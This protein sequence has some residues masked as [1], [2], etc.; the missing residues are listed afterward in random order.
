MVK[1]THSGSEDHTHSAFAGAHKRLEQMPLS[2]DLDERARELFRALKPFLK[3]KPQQWTPDWCFAFLVERQLKATSDFIDYNASINH[4]S[5]LDQKYL[6]LKKKEMKEFYDQKDTRVSKNS[7]FENKFF[8]KMLEEKEVAIDAAL[9]ID[10]KYFLDLD[11][12]IAFIGEA[13]QQSK[14][15]AR[16]ADAFYEEWLEHQYKALLKQQEKRVVFKEHFSANDLPTLSAEDMREIDNFLARG[17][18]ELQRKGV[19][20]LSANEMTALLAESQGGKT[21]RFS[22]RRPVPG[23]VRRVVMSEQIDNAKPL[24]P[25]G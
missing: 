14:K 22:G 16:L 1:D 18:E 21:V 7:Y 8:L 19:S 23:T 4:L 20:L 25:K 17:E 10:E 24:K 9:V 11:E 5:L 3:E 15:P 6:V 2:F 13:L 12:K